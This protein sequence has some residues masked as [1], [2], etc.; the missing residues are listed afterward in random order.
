MPKSPFGGS[1]RFT[2]KSRPTVQLKVPSQGN[3]LLQNMLRQQTQVDDE[4]R[5]GQQRQNVGQQVGEV[6]SEFSGGIAPI[7]STLAQ[8]GKPT[9]DLNRP[10][11]EAADSAI[12][13]G[14]QQAV[15]LGQNVTKL[16]NSPNLRT[17]TS[18]G[19][20]NISG[21]GNQ[22]GN[23]SLQLEGMKNDPNVSEFAE[24]KSTTEQLFQQYRKYITGV[25]A[26]FPELQMLQPIFP[27]TNDP[28]SNYVS[29][30]LSA[31]KTMSTNEQT[32]L[33]YFEKRG[34]QIGNLKGTFPVNSEEVRKMALNS[35]INVDPSTIPLSLDEEKKQ[36]LRNR[37]LGI[38]NA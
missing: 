37:Y 16:I 17:R 15:N 33:D 9:I 35:G 10:F 23:V 4:R 7:G 29:K 12:R 3:L 6:Q 25:Q 14:R 1:G 28:P 21:Y 19:P 31:L 8:G 5:I 2:P 32:A 11:P 36:R 20:F 34:Y 26:G 13:L 27:V 24:F 18:R 38:K 22:I 30:S